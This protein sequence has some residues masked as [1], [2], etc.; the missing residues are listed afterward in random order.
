MAKTKTTMLTT[1]RSPLN[2]GT[3]A[4]GGFVT[5][6]EVIPRGGA[7]RNPKELHRPGPP[8]KPSSSLLVPQCTS[9]LQTFLLP[10]ST[11]S[12]KLRWYSNHIK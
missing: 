11:L 7:E 3:Q 12:V 1:D 4:R 6:E 9:Q 2:P 10:L 5:S 8:R